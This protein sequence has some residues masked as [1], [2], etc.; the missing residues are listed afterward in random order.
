[1]Q[2]YSY[3]LSDGRL[4]QGSAPPPYVPLPFD[5]IVLAAM[6]YQPDMPGFKVIYAPLDDGP[7]P[8]PAERRQIRTT[9]NEVARLVRGGQRVLVTC[10]QGRNRSGVIAGLALVELGVPGAHAARKIRRLRNGLTNPYFHEMVVQS[11][12]RTT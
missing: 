6:E 10:M 1:M 12:R 2:D 7:P 3:L 9:S 11:A 5:V 8:T 4:A